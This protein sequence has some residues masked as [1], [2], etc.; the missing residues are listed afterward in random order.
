MSKRKASRQS[1]MSIFDQIGEVIGLVTCVRNSLD[2][3]NNFDRVVT[4][5]IA[6]RELRSADNRLL[7]AIRRGNRLGCTEP[8][9]RADAAH[10]NEDAK[11]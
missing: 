2:Y 10:N 7:A 6:I 4:L 1:F 5:G 9:L 3:K 11:P 8:Q